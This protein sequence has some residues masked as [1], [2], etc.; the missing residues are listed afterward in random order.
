MKKAKIVKAPLDGTGWFA[1]T[2]KNTSI[3][4]RE[5]LE[6]II[7][8]LSSL[9]GAEEIY[10]RENSR[11]NTFYAVQLAGFSCYQSATNV[12]LDLSSMALKKGLSK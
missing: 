4:Q 3:S 11:G 12:I 7:I 10:K 9:L 2:T 5:T 8:N 1:S 6:Q